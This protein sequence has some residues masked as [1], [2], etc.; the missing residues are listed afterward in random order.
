MNVP[1]GLRSFHGERRAGYNAVDFDYCGTRHITFRHHALCSPHC[2]DWGPDAPWSAVAM[3]ADGLLTEIL[4]DRGLCRAC[5]TS[6]D[7]QAL[8]DEFGGEVVQ[9]LPEQ[10]SLWDWEVIEWVEAWM[11]ARECKGR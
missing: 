10:W 2:F 11:A 8:V 3:L 7:M 9:Y 5:C 4:G 6:A 1:I